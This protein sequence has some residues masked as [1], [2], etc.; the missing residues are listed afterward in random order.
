MMNISS[1]ISYIFKQLPERSNNL[2]E[3]LLYSKLY[4]C[5][6]WLAIFIDLYMI[7]RGHEIIGLILILMLIPFMKNFHDRNF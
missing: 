5:C 6:V 2:V 4:Y 1:R 7:Y 3:R